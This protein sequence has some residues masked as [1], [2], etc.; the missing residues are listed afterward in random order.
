MRKFR[1]KIKLNKCDIVFKEELGAGCIASED[2]EMPD[3]KPDG[4]LAMSLLSLGEELR[5][6]V[7]EIEI[8]EVKDED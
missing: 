4:M 5:D 8:N 1:I 6:E 2:V 7:V 3:G